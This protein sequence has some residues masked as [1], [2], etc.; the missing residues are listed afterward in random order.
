MMTEEQFKAFMERYQSIGDNMV[1]TMRGIK[2]DVYDE[3]T[4]ELFKK[5]IINLKKLTDDYVKGI[6]SCKKMY[7][8]SNK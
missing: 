6:K 5:F 3:E 2:I 4:L 1:K 8:D 7:E